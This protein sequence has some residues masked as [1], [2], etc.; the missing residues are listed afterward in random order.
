LTVLFACT[1]MQSQ[2]IHYKSKNSGGLHETEWKNQ[3]PDVYWPFISFQ[4]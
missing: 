3:V 2:N 4:W 1:V